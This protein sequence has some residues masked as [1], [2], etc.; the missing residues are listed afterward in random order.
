MTG[1]KVIQKTFTYCLKPTIKQKTLFAQYVGAARFIFNWGLSGI[2]KAFDGKEKIPSYADMTNQLP[3]LKE[4][5]ETQWL[6]E[7]HS[8]VLQQSL[9]DLDLVLNAWFF[10]VLSRLRRFC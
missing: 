9:K 10:C 4:A 5:L 7:V 1:M 8:Q 6:K 2:K 3:Q